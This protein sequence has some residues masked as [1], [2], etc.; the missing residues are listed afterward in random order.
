VRESVREGRVGRWGEA[1]RGVPLLAIAFAAVWLS[2][3]PAGVIA[4][5]SLALLLVVASIWQRSFRPLIL[6]SVAMVLGFG[7]AAFYIVPAAFEQRWVQIGQAIGE[8]LRPAQNFLFTGS[9]DPEFVLFN[10]KVS[11]VALGTILVTA[12][13]AVFSARYRRDDPLLWWMLL[14]LTGA[15]VFLMFPAS[16]WL[17]RYLP[18]LQFVQFPWR[19]LIPL[20]IP[21]AVFLALAIGRAQKRWIWY[22]ALA[23]IVITTAAAIVRNAWWDSEDIPA[24]VAAIHSGRGYDGT[25]EY[26]P[27]GCDRY[28]LPGAPQDGQDS[29]DAQQPPPS[30]PIAILDSDLDEIVP[31]DSS[32]FRIEKWTSENKTI[33]VE[34][35]EQVAIALR[36]VKYPAWET[37]L[38]GVAVESSGLRE[39]AQ[40]VVQVPPGSHRFEVFFRRTPDRLAGAA[41]SA[42]SAVV[43]L[44]SGILL[45]RRE[46]SR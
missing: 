39:T 1:W 45:R 15:S 7:L 31:A 30:P 16:I 20:D 34:T 27:V 11:S 13:A 42:L 44:G 43:L 9:S 4:T 24:L 8:N 5:Y 32:H 36:L 3:A 35:P 40:M 38:D 22:G 10:W 41:I 19:W 14:A 17:W 12:I 26:A 18:K 29:E 37:R 6:G 25:D 23:A 46:A 28:N 2:N 21:F 33:R